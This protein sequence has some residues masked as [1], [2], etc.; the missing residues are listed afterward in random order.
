MPCRYDPT[1]EEEAAAKD[2]DAYRELLSKQS[3]LTRLLCIACKKMEE[4]NVPI[5]RELLSWWK[6]HQE[7]DKGREEKKRQEKLNKQLKDLT[8]KELEEELK[9]RKQEQKKI[10]YE[11]CQ[12]DEAFDKDWVIKCKQPVV[13]GSSYCTNHYGK[14]CRC[15]KQAVRTCDATV[16]GP[17]MCGGYNCGSCRCH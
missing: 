15:G 4:Y 16:V 12:F 6:T 5:T 14:T 13:L 2:T 8:L 3:H 11:G 17:L 1:P 10:K 9:R 7:E